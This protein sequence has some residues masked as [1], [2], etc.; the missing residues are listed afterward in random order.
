MFTS[1][2]FLL[3]L[4][5]LLAGSVAFLVTDQTD[6]DWLPELMWMVVIAATGYRIRRRW[7][8]RSK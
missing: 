3:Y 7:S 6:S 1:K 2:E 8:K 5:V 4:G